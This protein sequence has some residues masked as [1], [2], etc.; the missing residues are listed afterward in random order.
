MWKWMK[1]IAV[2]GTFQD[3][4]SRSSQTV[5]SRTLQPRYLLRILDAMRDRPSL[6]VVKFTMSFSRMGCAEIVV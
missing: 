4:A 1:I 3:Q 2:L 5:Y 6:M